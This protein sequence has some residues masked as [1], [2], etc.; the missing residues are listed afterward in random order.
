M[1]LLVS[2]IG[3]D[4][5]RPASVY[6]GSDSRITWDSTSKWD[7]ARKVFGFKNHPDILGYCGDA[8]F[9]TQVLGQLIELG[10]AGLLFESQSDGQT[11]FE[12]IK[13]KLIQIFKNYPYQSV[14]RDYL[15]IL[16]AS[17]D[18]T[19]GFSCRVIEWTPRDGW[20][21]KQAVYGHHSDKLFVLGSGASAFLQTFDG[22]WQSDNSR[23]SRAIFHCLCDTLSKGTDPQCGGA[24]QLVGLY[25]KWNAKNFGIIWNSRRYFLGVDIT[26][27]DRVAD[28]EWRNDLFERCDGH[29]MQRLPG[30][31]RQPNPLR[32]SQDLET[33]KQ[34][35]SPGPII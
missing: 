7:F 31:Q 13:K 35:N 29:T 33:R 1:T 16:H 8:F 26:S 21:F 3:I 2:W 12:A 32:G 18:P 4:S 9:P 28:I 25:T 10:D 19:G 6:I 24:P 27:E 23:T 30:A 34:S 17:R 14:L 11:K 20:K 22:Y 5:R 15:G